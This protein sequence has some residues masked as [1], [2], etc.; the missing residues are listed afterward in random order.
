MDFLYNVSIDPVLQIVEDPVFFI[1]VIAEGLMAG[2]RP[3]DATRWRRQREVTL[4]GPIHDA[5]RRVQHDA[6][7]LK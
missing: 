6:P 2:R 7:R 4:M 1:Q 3:C 5:E